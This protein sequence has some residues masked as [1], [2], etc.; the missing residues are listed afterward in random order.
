MTD[1][2]QVLNYGNMQELIEQ[3]DWHIAVREEEVY[4]LA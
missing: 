3:I 2:L 1:H 4:K